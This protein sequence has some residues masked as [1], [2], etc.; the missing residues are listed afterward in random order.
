VKEKER[1]ELMQLY[2][3]V[4]RKEKDDETSVRVLFFLIRIFTYMMLI[5]FIDSYLSFS[6]PI[7]L[8]NSFYND[9]H[10]SMMIIEL[11]DVE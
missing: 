7:K 6:A 1:Y 9:G 8:I 10:G 3:H 11:T 5:S 4:H 2:A